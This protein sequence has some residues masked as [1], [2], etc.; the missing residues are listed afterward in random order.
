MITIIGLGPDDCQHWT[1]A[2]ARALQQA[3]KVYLRT[4]HHPSVADISAPTVSF[5]HLSSQAPAAI[6]GEVLRL[7]QERP[8]LVYA[9]PGHPTCD[10]ASVPLILAEAARLKLPIQLI[11]GLSYAD[12]ALAALRLS[13]SPSL[14]L[15]EATSLA[16]RYH[17]PLEPDRP[18]L[19]LHLHSAELALRIKRPLLN[20]YP[21][22]FEV[23]LL[24]APGAAAERTVVCRLN[25]IELQPLEPFAILYLPPDTAT[26]GFTTFQ[27]IIAQLRSPEGCPWDRQQSHQSLR[28]YLLEE[29]Y[30]VLEALDA[31]DPAALADELGDLLLQI[32]LHTQIAVDQGEFKM[33]AVLDHINRKM[34]RRHP[35]VFGEV[36]AHH[37]DE[38]TANW[39]VIKRAEKAAKG[40]AEPAPSNLD[41]VPV[42][43]PALA[44]ALAISQKAKRVGFEWANIDG[45]LDKIIEEAQEITEATDLTHLESEI[46]DLLFSVVNLARW[47]NIDPESA[48]RATN[49]RFKQRFR[50]MEYLAEGRGQH[51]AELTLEQMDELWA[52]AKAKL[53]S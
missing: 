6:A 32:V 28:P 44:A 3:N 41:G 7:A 45:V 40:Q 26:S 2:A 20:A 24:Q 38:V 12:A 35:H 33:G 31:A 11:P 42:A 13:A 23:T 17:P 9:A 36:I 29:T 1:Q 10:D 47:R 30:E 25:Q 8:E 21:A 51:L 19:V 49:A 52:E 16:A 15:V 43:L 5:D 14:Q 53:S 37:A 27:E 4:V 34:L 48:L 22:D 50:R 18:A 39:E 46:G